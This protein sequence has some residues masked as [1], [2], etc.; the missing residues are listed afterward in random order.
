MNTLPTACPFCG[1]EM[2][3]THLNCREC[4]THIDGR[5]TI[6]GASQL[7]P[8]H[9]EF[10]DK[11]VSRLEPEQ[12]DFVETF[13]RCEGK[14]KSMEAELGLSYPT[15]R[16]RLDEIIRALGYEPELQAV[17]SAVSEERR[18]AILED[19]DTGKI[20]A[21]VAMRMLQEREG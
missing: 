6:S 16:N 20:S 2:I 11:F 15:I 5:F 13:V 10:M 17:A 8:E 14:I 9:I 1:G 18:L 3:V 12:L 7:K 19:L 21:E 4:D